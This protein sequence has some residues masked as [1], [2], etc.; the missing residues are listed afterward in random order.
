MSK[1]VVDRCL[2][3][4]NLSEDDLAELL[5]MQVEDVDPALRDMGDD[6]FRIADAIKQEL[7]RLEFKKKTT[8]QKQEIFERENALAWLDP[9]SP[10]MG[11]EGIV[12]FSPT[13]GRAGLEKEILAEINHAMGIIAKFNDKYGKR[14]RW[15]GAAGARGL[16]EKYAGGEGLM[17]KVGLGKIARLGPWRYMGDQQA[18]KDML[19]TLL[20]GKVPEGVSIPDAMEFAKAVRS[21][22]DYLHEERNKYGG[23]GGVEIRYLKNYFPIAAN[24][25]KVGRVDRKVFADYV[26][27]RIDLKQVGIGMA[28]FAHKRK[29]SAKRGK[30][31]EKAEPY[32]RDEIYDVILKIHDDITTGGAAAN[33]SKE[34]LL[35][36]SFRAKTDNQRRVFIWKDGKSALEYQER[37]GDDE[38]FDALIGMATVEAQRIASQ[39]RLGAN[40]NAMA[41]L[42]AEDAS[43]GQRK[44]MKDFILKMKERYPD[45]WLKRMYVMD[46]TNMAERIKE[47]R[48]GKDDIERMENSERSNM[49]RLAKWG[50]TFA[51]EY[52]ELAARRREI[53][54]MDIAR[55][56]TTEQRILSALIERTVPLTAWKRTTWNTTRDS[57]LSEDGDRNLWEK[58]RQGR[59]GADLESRMGRQVDRI[60]NQ[61][62]LLNPM[63]DT[64]T[65]RR[66]AELTSSIHNLFTAPW[67]GK[68]ALETWTLDPI[69]TAFQ[70]KQAGM[71]AKAT[72]K[73]D[74]E[75]RTRKLGG[76]LAQSYAPVLRALWVPHSA[77]LIAKAGGGKA[78]F[79]TEE[80]WRHFNVQRTLGQHHQQL[81]IVRGDRQGENYGHKWTQRYVNHAA[82]ISGVTRSS[83]LQSTALQ[84]DIWMHL[85]SRTDPDPLIRES[86]ESLEPAERDFWRQYGIEAEDFDMLTH[87][88]PQFRVD[89]YLDVE[90]NL[91]VNMIDLD[92]MVRSGSDEVAEL[93]RK[94]RSM[95]MVISEEKGLQK[96]SVRLQEHLVGSSKPGGLRHIAMSTMA[97]FRKYGLMDI[98]TGTVRMYGGQ[99]SGSKIGE[100]FA[101]TAAVFAGELLLQQLKQA[102]IEGREPDIIPNRHTMMKAAGN[103]FNLMRLAGW[104][105]GEDMGRDAILH[106]MLGPFGSYGADMI[107]N[108]AY[109]ASYLTPSIFDPTSP[110]AWGPNTDPLGVGRGAYKTMRGIKGLTPATNLW[111]TSL[112]FDRWLDA[113]VSGTVKKAAVDRHIRRETRSQL[114]GE[115]DTFMRSF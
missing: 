34:A 83:E 102:L 104:T 36:E 63:Q 65:N 5:E 55:G 78:P 56:G 89:D 7:E 33:A 70:R 3:R 79:R 80:Q 22:L 23:N 91:Y 12:G 73:V 17:G 101:Q 53:E 30:W 75:G 94:I 109:T 84:R 67:L 76:Y 93:G 58:L 19:L 18:Y 108:A 64:Y 45:D 105:P 24:S 40:P 86:W 115:G 35:N 41:R 87:R 110:S 9:T 14:T 71:A 28:E 96:P 59:G 42:L 29:V 82:N 43:Y 106:A 11:V 77:N 68:V 38:L 47:P 48:W 99:E 61:M 69:H 50:H 16:D 15:V 114:R 62:E 113:A 54:D 21:M 13:S 39:R 26:I 32:T 31:G 90:G 103:T 97:G 57:L 49:R 98:T 95:M 72:T 27:D 60:S 37:F 6:G 81:N 4:S 10:L 88:I 1:S 107:G 100:A 112:L 74:S 52:D 111:Y 85:S 2:L 92:G 25:Q 66:L 8:L 44:M 46:F 20:D 51:D